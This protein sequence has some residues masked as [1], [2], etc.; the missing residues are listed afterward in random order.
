MSLALSIDNLPR[1]ASSPFKWVVAIVATVLITNLGPGWLSIIPDWLVFP[2]S[3]IV[4]GSLTW[5]AREASIGGIAVQE[6]TRGFA[7]LIDKPIE[8]AVVVLAEGTFKGRGLDVTQSIP[9]L[10]WLALG[11]AAIIVA[12]RFG[13]SA[14]ALTTSICVAFLVLFGLWQN[15]MI[16]LSNVLV[17]VTLATLLGLALGIWSF[18]SAHVENVTRGIMNVMQTVPIFAYLIPTLLLF[19]YGPSAALVAT[20]AYA[21]PP[22]VHNTVL[23]LKSVP[24]ETIEC[25]RMTGCTQRQLLWQVQLPTALAKIA[26]GLNQSIMMTLNMVII[27][28][29]IGAG[30]LGFDVLKALRKL[31]IGSG[32]EAGMGIVALAIILDRISQAVAKRAA[33]GKHREPG[34]WPIWKLVGLWLVVATGIAYMFDPVQAWPKDYVISTAAFWNDLVTWINIEWFDVLD[35]F[36]TFALLEVM[37]PFRD[38]LAAAPWTMMIGLLAIGAYALGGARLAI[39]CA[40]L[41]LAIVMT[42][43]WGPAMNSLYLILISVTLAV[44]MGFPVGFWLASRPQLQTAANLSLDTLQTLPTLVYLL[45]AVM[46]FRIG[47]VSAVIAVTLYATAPAIRYAMIGMSQVPLARLEAAQISGCTRWQTLRWIR[48][49]AALPTLLIGVNQT[50]MM[51][52]SMLIIAA[53]VGTKDLGQEILIALNR[54]LVGQ[55]IVAGLCVACLALIADALLKAGAARAV[56]HRHKKE[57]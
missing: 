45:P 10:S 24:A 20:V 30:G 49:P 5:F 1:I 54:S 36:R 16:T 33:H 15:A 23:A 56:T 13:G 25:G 35:A 37:R 6:I 57:D 7:E 3:D 52:F 39:Y 21:L 8:A 12:H 51:A 48:F 17:S 19:G 41:A 44:I 40:A 31:D 26:V 32:L 18:R 27:A 2:V 28:S 50:I 47:D 29:M 55:G 43:Y 53:L 38:A 4:G 34:Q 9:P 42:G 46:L 11:G 14:L 22:M